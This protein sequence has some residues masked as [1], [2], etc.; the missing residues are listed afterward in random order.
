[1]VA[2]SDKAHKTSPAPATD[3]AEAAPGEAARSI[4]YRGAGWGMLG[5]NYRCRRVESVT[6]TSVP[7]TI[8]TKS[9]ALFCGAVNGA[10]GGPPPVRR[11]FLSRSAAALFASLM[12]T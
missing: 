6:H 9:S 7:F 1:M 3:K 5:I 8:G 10:G 2:P 11:I 12:S 4:D